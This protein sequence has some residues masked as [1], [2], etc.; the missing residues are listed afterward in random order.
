MACNADGS[1]LVASIYPAEI[2]TSLD[3]GQT[4]SNKNNNLSNIMNK[5]IFSL[6]ENHALIN[7]VFS[8]YGNVLVGLGDPIDFLSGGNHTYISVDSGKT[9]KKTNLFMHDWKIAINFDGS[10]IFAVGDHMYTSTDYGNTWNRIVNKINV[11][12]GIGF[13]GIAC[14]SDGSKMVVAYGGGI[15]TSSDYGKTW[16][17]IIKVTHKNI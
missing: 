2:Y 3:F 7:I 4:W 1:K 9:W 13:N 14:N 17:L 8:P 10:K 6:D 5:N 15:Y 16:N 11:T 12:N